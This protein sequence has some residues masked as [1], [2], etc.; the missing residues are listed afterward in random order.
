M[1]R[2]KKKENVNHKNSFTTLEVVILIFISVVVSLIIGSLVTNKLNQNKLHN[3]D[4][5]LKK[6]IKNYNYIVDNYYE[7]VDKEE[8][9]NNAIKGMLESLEDDYS[10]LID[11]DDSDTFDIQLEGEYEGIG[12]QI[13]G[14]TTGE[15]VV[16]DVFDDSPADSAGLK[17]GDIIKKIDDLD[18]TSEKVNDVSSYIREGNK[19]EFTIKIERDSKEKEIKIK[20]KKVTIKAV[21]SKTFK[22][23]DKK[24]GY[25]YIELF[26]NI[27]YKQFAEELEKLE[28]DDIDSL[29]IDVRDNSG[30]HLSTAVNIISLFLNSKHVIYQTETKGEIEKFYSKGNETK[31][32]PIVVLQNKN[33]ASASEMLSSTL[34]EEYGATIVGEVSYGKGTVQELLDLNDD[35]E[36]KITTKKWLTPKGNWINKKGVSVDVEVSLDDKYYE[37]PSDET[38]N[39]LQKALEE[40][41][42]K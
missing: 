16:Y 33:S 10:Y 3:D 23:D 42:K 24:I 7:D 17:V 4:T 2:T 1:A 6:F 20:R 30:G 5:E 27:A 29:I 36:Y 26:S 18:C 19:S 15:V 28:K 37:N 14:L 25:I 13:V 8:L 34:K 41:I 32:Y 39:Q 9:L 21:T 22:K 31:K 12:I 11:E 35:I 38:D 40:I